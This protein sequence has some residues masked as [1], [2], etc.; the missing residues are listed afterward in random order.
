MTRLHR[1]TAAA[2]RVVADPR[3][4]VA[5]VGSVAVWIAAGSACAWSDT[6]HRVADTA[7]TVI[8]Y[9]LAVLVLTAQARDTAAVQAK[10]DELIRATAGARD[11]LI[12]AEDRDPAEI[13]ARRI[14]DRGEC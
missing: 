12:R 8:G 7:M 9:W 4:F 2:G 14:G 1:F 6:W 10:L 3:A 11:T 5:A 13:D